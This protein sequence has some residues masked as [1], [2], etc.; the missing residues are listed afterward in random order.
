MN[1]KKNR[2]MNDYVRFWHM[3]FNWKCIVKTVWSRSLMWFLCFFSRLF[4][5]ISIQFI[6]MASICYV[7]TDR[8]KQKLFFFWSTNK[9]N[10][11]IYTFFPD[12]SNIYVITI[13][14]MNENKE[15]TISDVHMFDIARIHLHAF[16]IF[17]HHFFFFFLVSFIFVYFLRLQSTM[18][19]NMGYKLMTHK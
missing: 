5:C 6:R 12:L 9:C 1:Q 3:Q 17:F 14:K 16:Y 2:V 13:P 19:A 4:S 15:K 7:Q 8:Q 10:P 18:N 11:S